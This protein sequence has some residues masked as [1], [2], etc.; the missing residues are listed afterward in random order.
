MKK[1]E[2]KY[3]LLKGVLILVLVAILLTW[4]IPV[5]E[6]SSATFVEDGMQRIGLSNLSWIIFY[7]LIIFLLV[8]GGLYGVLSK[9]GAY[10]RLVEGIAKN[11]SKH[12]KLA[13]VVLSIVIAVLTSLL[14][15]SFALL[16]FIPFVIAILKRMK[17]DK[18]TILATTFGAMLVGV[19]GATYGTEGLQVF[20]DV[21][22]MGGINNASVLVRAGILAIGLVL[23]NFFTLVHMDKTEKTAESKE[24]FEIEPMK[25]EIKCSINYYWY[26]YVNISNS[27]FC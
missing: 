12:K 24:I 18:M 14:T 13:V 25:E 4:L 5:G 17:L 7:A 22:Y 15:Q 20:D 10:E 19:L 16:I 21:R 3:G 11:F 1:K 26:R 27:C 2:K 6:F 9:V 23:F 8:I